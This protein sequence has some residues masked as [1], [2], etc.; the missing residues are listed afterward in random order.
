MSVDPEVMSALKGALAAL[1]RNPQ[2]PVPTGALA[3]IAKVAHPGLE[4][5]IDLRASQEIGAPLVL[6]KQHSDETALFTPLTGRQKQVAALVLEGC[7]NREIAARLGISI[8]TVKDHVH[9]ILHRLGLPSR[10]ALIAASRAMHK[11]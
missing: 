9:A 1:A 8:A 7:T 2:H 5:R 10:S 6:F 4:M 11:G 3:E